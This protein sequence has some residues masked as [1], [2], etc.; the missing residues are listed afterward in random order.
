M[1]RKRRKRR[2]WILSSSVPPP[3]PSLTSS[4]SSYIAKLIQHV[5]NFEKFGEVLNDE[6]LLKQ[7]DVA[8][9]VHG[10]TLRDQGGS[11]V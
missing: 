5:V 10:T 9:M 1:R 3:S 7:Y 6:K 11:S 2:E 4:S 8:F